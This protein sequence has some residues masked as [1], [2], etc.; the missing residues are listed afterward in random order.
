MRSALTKVEGA[1]RSRPPRIVSAPHRCSADRNGLSGAGVLLRSLA[2]KREVRSPLCCT[3]PV[4]LS[5]QDVNAA[6]RTNEPH[7]Q[8]WQAMLR[9][10]GARCANR[11]GGFQTGRTVARYEAAGWLVGCRRPWLMSRR[12]TY[13][14]CRFSFTERRSA[15]W[16]RWL[17]RPGPLGNC[18]SRTLVR[19]HEAVTVG[20]STRWASVTY[21]A[22]SSRVLNLC[23]L[24]R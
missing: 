19:G 5:P 6:H 16:Q 4:V 23:C 1:S 13:S 20:R 2:G 11:C 14:Y 7:L 21:A 15:R 24:R 18:I 3:E 17:Q 9:A 8:Q 12:K 10:E 22:H